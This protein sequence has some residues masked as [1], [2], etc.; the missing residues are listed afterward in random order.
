[1]QFWTKIKRS[2]FFTV[3]PLC[4]GLEKNGKVMVTITWKPTSN[5][6]F[7]WLT[8][9]VLCFIP[10]SLE[11]FKLFLRAG[12]ENNITL[13][14]VNIWAHCVLNSKLVL[15]IHHCILDF[16]SYL[17]HACVP[18]ILKN[19]L[20]NEILQPKTGSSPSRH[21][22]YVINGVGSTLINF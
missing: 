5:R 12:L 16:V 13:F 11:K 1:M 14:F 22:M 18:L 15:Y 17:I 7:S 10:I 8:D 6:S 21:L 4:L 19:Q 9:S 2:E 3:C 20:K